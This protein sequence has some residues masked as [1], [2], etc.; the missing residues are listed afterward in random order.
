M[1]NPY[2]ATVQ[3][4]GGMQRLDGSVTFTDGANQPGGGPNPVTSGAL[5]TVTLVSGTALQ[6]ST[7]RTK[8]VA[9][10]YT[11]DA[12]NNVA[13]VKVE[14]SPDNTT[15]TALATISF[16]AAVNNTGAITDLVDVQVPQSW[17][18]KV[19]VVHA[20]IGTAGVV[21]AY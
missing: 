5:P 16:A 14:L 13:T 8:T 10:F 2:P 4:S 11:L 3:D 6:V 18:I 19:T 1:G 7:V 15:F 9:L 12:T 20:T 17:W 21:V